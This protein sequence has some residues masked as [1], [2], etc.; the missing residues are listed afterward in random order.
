M[1][2]DG[3]LLAWLVD[4]RSAIEVLS[5]WAALEPSLDDI[6]ASDLVERIGQ[7]ANQSGAIV[8]RSLRKLHLSRV[9][10][11][12]GISDLADKMLQSIAQQ[13]LGGA[14]KAKR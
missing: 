11:D 8:R 4:D 3:A 6:E 7:L 9:I 14:K 12:G 13:R 1:T 10:V 2:S 5:A